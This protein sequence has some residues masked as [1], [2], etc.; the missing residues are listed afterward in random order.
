MKHG[1]S[2][3]CIIARLERNGFD[4]LTS[5]VCAAQLSAAAAA[6]EAGFGRPRP[7]PIYWVRGLIVKLSPGDLSALVA[8]LGGS[9][10]GISGLADVAA[11]APRASLNRR[12]ASRKTAAASMDLIISHIEK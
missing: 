9:L 5:Y 6:R 2:R 11:A 7:S 10:A 12:S 1:N 3:A 4:E 8:E